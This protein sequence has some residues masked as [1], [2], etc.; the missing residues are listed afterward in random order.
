[1]AL[2]AIGFDLDGTLYP[3]WAL[4]L[5]SIDLGIGNARLL[6]AFGKARRRLRERSIAATSLLEFRQAQA[7][8]VAELLGTGTG[9]AYV[10]AI[11]NLI[12]NQVETRFAAIMPFPGV[13]HC[14]ET[15]K[16][17]GV[18]LGLLSDLPPW[19]KLEFLGLDRFFEIAQCSEDSGALKPHP[20][21]FLKLARSLGVEPAEML[22]VGNNMNYDVIGAGKLGMKTALRTRL[23]HRRAEV[24]CFNDWGNLESWLLGM[25]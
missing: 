15:L 7:D 1:M 11:E 2:K 13:A 23:V 24:Y 18:L 4:Y 19:K 10:S 8:M 20:A 14:L 25:L 12:Y 3:G 17:R 9:A 21:S 22:Y 5:R 6:A 16:G